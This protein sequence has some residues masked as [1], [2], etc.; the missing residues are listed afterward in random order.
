MN[1]KIH[2]R[3][4]ILLAKIGRIEAAIA[5]GHEAADEFGERMRQVLDGSRGLMHFGLDVRVDL[6]LEHDVLENV[7]EKT[8]RVTVELEQD[9]LALERH[10]YGQRV[11]AG[12]CH[13]V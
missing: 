9:V 8:R 13:S 11:E 1:F 4:L 7:E 3:F 2:E 10:D 5:Q 12:R 6:E